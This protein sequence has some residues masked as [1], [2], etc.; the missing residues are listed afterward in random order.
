MR[1]DKVQIIFLQ[2][3][4]MSKNEHKKLKKFGYLNSFFSSC[5]NSRKR[6]V[7]TVISNSLNFELIIEKSDTQ[8]R[9]VI[10]KGRIDSI[11]VTFANIYTPPESDRKFFKS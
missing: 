6:G 2:E 10:I 9:Y 1:K 5:E 11:L 3:T 7:A 8:G 4:H